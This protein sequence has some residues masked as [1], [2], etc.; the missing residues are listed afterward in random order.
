M[1]EAPIAEQPRPPAAEDGAGGGPREW[2]GAQVVNNA[3]RLLLGHLDEEFADNPEP[4]EAEW[5]RPDDGDHGPDE[6]D[7]PTE[8][9]LAEAAPRERSS[10][11]RSQR[12][13]QRLFE[14]WRED[15][16]APCRDA[17]AP[18]RLELWCDRPQP[19]FPGHRIPRKKE[20]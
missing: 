8:Q 2:T 20:S 11:L 12:T 3:D 19:D 1:E 18:P 5:D 16:A 14:Q 9:E 4:S 10:S 13:T 7:W 6:E 15:A 17:P